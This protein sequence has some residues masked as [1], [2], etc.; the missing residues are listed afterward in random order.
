MSR[1][2]YNLVIDSLNFLA[3]KIRLC[4]VLNLHDINI[5]LENILR[6]IINQ[7]YQDRNFTNLNSV[8]GNFTAIDLGDDI[9]EIAI[10]ITSDTSLQ[11]AKETIQKYK[12]EYGYKKLIMLYATLKKPERTFDF[13]TLIDNRFAFEEWDFN[14]LNKKI[15]NCESENLEKIC[16]ICNTD[17]LPNFSIEKYIDVTATENW[18]NLTNDDIRNFEE[19]I[20]EVNSTMKQFRITKFCMD[21]ASGKAE[22]EKFDDR[23]IS[24]MKFRIFEVCQEELIEF[25]ELNEKQEN[26]SDNEILSLINKYTEKAYSI[27]SE[28]SKDFHYPLSNKDSI[29]KIVLALIDECYLSFDE[30][31]IYF[32]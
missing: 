2:S 22:I 3:N 15:N 17:I 24:A 21:I 20:K 11:K 18:E 9:N 16:R 23:D 31:G 5:H 27:I 25:C 30:K 19:K 12:S 32:S 10:Q 26:L 29:R 7:I 4:S 6:D 28:K 8:S 13:N 1:N 14:D